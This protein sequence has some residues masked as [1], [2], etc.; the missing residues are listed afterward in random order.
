MVCAKGASGS[1]R[2]KERPVLRIALLTFILMFLALSMLYRAWRI[3]R[4]LQSGKW[5]MR[6]VEVLLA[7][8]PKVYWR[9]VIMNGVTLA[10][11]LCAAVVVLRALVIA[12]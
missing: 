2:D 4:A 10:I 11:S 1:R 7:D 6:G 5:P 12:N 8:R 9:L 3:Y